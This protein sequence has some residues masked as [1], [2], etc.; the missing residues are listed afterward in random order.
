VDARLPGLTVSGPDEKTYV[1]FNDVTLRVRHLPLMVVAD[2]RLMLMADGLGRFLNLPVVDKTGLTNLY[3]YS[4]G[5]NVH[6]QRQLE[7][8]TT[9]RAAVDKIL[10]DLGLGLAPD[11]APLDMLVVKKVD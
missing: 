7:N 5:W 6:V 8:E 10:H 1:F 4:I 3:D 2:R 11:T 9:A